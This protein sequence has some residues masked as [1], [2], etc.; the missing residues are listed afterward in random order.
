MGGTMSEILNEVIPED[1][2]KILDE[3]A[4][5]YADKLLSDKPDMMEV[6]E[7]ADT[8]TLSKRYVYN[9]ISAGKLFSFKFGR[10]IVIPKESIRDYLV[11]NTL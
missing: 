6:D 9:A 11:H 1:T 2:R 7:V 10:K 4:K 8:L 5:D 3:M